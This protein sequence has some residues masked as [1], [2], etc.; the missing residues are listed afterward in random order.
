MGRPAAAPQL[1]DE[2]PGGEGALRLIRHLDNQDECDLYDVLAELTYGV[3]ARSRAERVAGFSYKSRVWLNGMPEPTAL[4]LKA[5]HGQFERGGI[6]DLESQAVFGHVQAIR[7]T[8]WRFRRT[9]C[10]RTRPG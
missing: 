9:S 7:G 6:E 1:L 5:M 8:G 10:V 2:L 3:V 4:V